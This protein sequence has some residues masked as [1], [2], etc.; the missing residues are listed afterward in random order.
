MGVFV[1]NMEGFDPRLKTPSNIMVVG[2]SKSGKTYWVTRLLRERREGM[3]RQPLNKV[4]YC[5]G[6]WQPTFQMV[7]DQ[8]PD[9][10]FVQGI[11]DDLYEGFEGQPGLLILDDLT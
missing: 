11:P 2:P 6:E 3:F 1:R 7:Q 8:D 9:V 5:Y 4:V 10:Q